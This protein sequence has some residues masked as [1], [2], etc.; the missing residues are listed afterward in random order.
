MSGFGT[1]TGRSR[2]A[3][4]TSFMSVDV[5]RRHSGSALRVRASLVER[6]ETRTLLAADAV[7]NGTADV[8]PDDAELQNYVIQHEGLTQH[9]AKE[10]KRPPTVGA[11][12]NLKRRGARALVESLGLDYRQLLREAKT[13]D[14]ESS[15]SA[16]QAKQLLREDLAIAI[17]DVQRVVTNFPEL[18]HRQQVGLVDL[19]YNLGF[20]RFKSHKGAVKALNAGDAALA[21]SVIT[22]SK[23][24]QREF[25][26]ERIADDLALLQSPFD[27]TTP[28][29]P[30]PGPGPG[31]TPPPPV[32]S[33]PSVAPAD[34]GTHGVRVSGGRV[35][36]PG[37]AVVDVG[38]A[39]L[40]IDVPELSKGHTWEG[41]APGNYIG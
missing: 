4:R 17:A 35:T 3:W 15:V 25:S 39:V 10:S 26:A 5:R 18:N 2:R 31:P 21:A 29:P 38:A 22:A 16:D 6:L 20:G 40:N 19:V 34:A 30:E 37:G 9:V 1:S 24:V 36:L 8:S 13:P 7:S 27:T 12:F 41:A 28:P 11:G 14:A 32:D 33:A 23:Y